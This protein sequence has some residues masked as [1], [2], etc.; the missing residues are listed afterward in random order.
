MQ[1][2][3]TNKPDNNNTDAASIKSIK[4]PD[5]KAALEA[6]NRE[7]AEERRRERERA[8]RCCGCGC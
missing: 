3:K 1:I 5:A 6:A 7:L 4:A 2:F 8:S